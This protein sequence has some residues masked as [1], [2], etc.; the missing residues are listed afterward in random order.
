MRTRSVLC[1]AT[2]CALA[3]T[4]VAVTVNGVPFLIQSG[5]SHS[6]VRVINGG[7][8]TMTGGDAGTVLLQDD[9][10][11]D[12]S[13]GFSDNVVVT[14]TATYENRGGSIFGSF[15]VRSFGTA[16]LAGTQS[17]SEF[18]SLQ[19]SG[20][21]IV[22]GG[23]TGDYVFAV[24]SSSVVIEAVSFGA[25]DGFIPP[26]SNKLVLSAGDPLFS[27]GTW[28]I[29]PGFF[30]VADRLVIVPTY[31]DGGSDT[32]FFYGDA[33]VEP[34]TGTLTLCKVPAVCLG[35]ANGDN[36]VDFEDLNL[37]LSNWNSVGPAGDTAPPPAGDGQVNFEDLNLVLANWGTGCS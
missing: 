14:N 15:S 3:A 23:D 18:V 5:D 22:R 29:G 32:I 7:A 17:L 4:A 31:I 37:V 25:L 36:S 9:S 30:R 16:T 28:E 34:W 8:V 26:G 33:E 10:T 11:W 24:Q 35:D 13:G 20:T 12:Q 19:D 21:L 2:V 1:V 27:R 6:I